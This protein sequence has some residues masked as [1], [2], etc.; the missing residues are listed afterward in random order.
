MRYIRYA[1]L[2][3]IAIALISV[4]LANR[5]LVEL[6]LMPTAFA[7]FLGYNFRI[8]LPLFVVVLGGIA[9]GLIIGFIIE[10]LREHKHRREADLKAREA[11]KLSREVN[12][13]KKQKHEGKDEVLAI[14]DE[15]S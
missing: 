12:R 14:L 2:G 11:K 5:G 15:A 9:I 1:Y 6:K 3:V 7:E 13:L 4:S 8:E 10:W